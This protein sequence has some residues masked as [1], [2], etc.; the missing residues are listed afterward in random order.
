MAIPKFDADLNIIS[1]LGDYPREDNGLETEDFKKR[2]DLAGNLL[3]KYINEIL[4]PNLDAIVD[5]DALL[6]SIL[7][8]TM[9]SED[10]AAQA[11][12]VGLRLNASRAEVCSIL[13][14]AYLGGDFAIPTTENF[15]AY[16]SGDNSVVVRRGACIMQGN[17][18]E[19]PA[20]YSETL[21]F[22]SGLGGTYRSDLICL[23]VIRD[24]DGND[25]IG[26]VLIPG[27]ESI[28]RFS[29]P[30]YKTGDLNAGAAVRDFPIY[31]LQMD[32]VTASLE[33][34][35]SSGRSRTITL[36]ASGWVGAS[37]PYTQTVT[38][39]GLTDGRRIMV[40]PVYGENAA[41]NIAMKEACASVSYAKRDGA[42]ITFVCLE[43]K[44]DVDI[45]VAAEVYV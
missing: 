4:V 14:K 28:S 11:K 21:I 17:L 44:P 8:P 45:T 29:D 26:I 7:D 30:E 19:L 3:K 5:V 9:T 6:K 35:F 39:A 27:T 37:A 36:P 41:A 10:M 34:L 18:I 23:R 38:A 31:R 20:G 25:A 22:K 15:K 12:A 2:F 24:Q 32:G 33:P 40:Y 13:E 16:F 43:D 1:S 42:D